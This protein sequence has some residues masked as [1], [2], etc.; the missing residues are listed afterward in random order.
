MAVYAFFTRRVFASIEF[1]E[2]QPYGYKL[3]VFRGRETGSYS[4]VFT[5]LK[6]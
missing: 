4:H 5:G 3:P 6:S 2:Y 1:A